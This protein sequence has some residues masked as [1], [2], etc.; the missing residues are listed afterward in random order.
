LILGLAVL[1]NPDYVIQPYHG[2]LLT[3]AIVAFCVFFNVFLAVRLPLTEALVLVLHILGVFVVI[4]PLWVMAPRGN[5][6]DTILRFT[7]DGG[8][9]DGALAA[10]IGM[11]PSIGMLIGYDCS[12]HM[13]EETQDASRT[14][15]LVLLWAVGSNA[16]MLLIVGITY[17]FCLGDLESVLDSPTGQPVIQ[18]FYNA[19]GSVAG[20]SIMVAVIII[21]F[22]SACIGQVATA[23]R[24]MWSFARDRG[25]S[26]NRP[27]LNFASLTLSKGYH[28]PPSLNWYRR[29]GTFH[30][31]Q[32]SFRQSSRPYCHLS[33]W[34]HIPPSTHLTPSGRCQ[35][36]SRTRSQSAV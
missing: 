33:T 3:M 19:T 6:H 8:W 26:C 27:C 31:T 9:K 32:S 29:H 7:N 30:S 16:V 34:D 11:V 22:I 24:Q 28:S 13:S 15:P 4:I 21:I 5:A 10:T 25:M 20:T 17:I 1:G 14:I 36:C 2:T 23:S 18:V 12:I 35:S